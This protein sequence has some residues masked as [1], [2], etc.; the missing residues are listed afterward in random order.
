MKRTPTSRRLL[1]VRALLLGC[2]FA[3]PLRAITKSEV[4]IPNNLVSLVASTHPRLLVTSNG[5]FTA[6]NTK[7]NS[8]D[9][10]MVLWKNKL[11]ARS[12]EIQNL[13]LEPLCV[14][15]TTGLSSVGGVVLERVYILALHYKLGLTGAAAAKTRL[16]SELTNIMGFPNWV[17]GEMVGVAKMTEAVA[18]AYDWLYNDWTANQ[19]TQLRAAIR[20][21]G[22]DPA[23]D[24]YSGGANWTQ[25]THNYNLVINSGVGMGALAICGQEPVIGESA[26]QNSLDHLIDGIAEYSSGGAWSEG[27][28]YWGFATGT[29]T[30]YLA[31]LKTAIGEDFGLSDVAGFCDTGNASLYTTNPLGKRYNFGDSDDDLGAM[32]FLFW[33]A[34]R[35]AKPEYGAWALTAADLPTIGTGIPLSMVFYDPAW[36]PAPGTVSLASPDKYFR[37]LETVSLRKSWTSV[38]DTM[39]VLKGYKDGVENHNDLDSGSFYL[40]ALGQV[41]AEDLGNDSYSLPGYQNDGSASP[42]RWDYYRKRPQGHNTLVIKPSGGVDQVPYAATP[43][44]RYKSSAGESFAIMDMT[45]AYPSGKNVTSAKRGVR[46]FGPQKKDV[47]VQDEVSMSTAGDADWYMHVKEPQSSFVIDTTDN[48]SATITTS[49]GN[50][51][52]L[53]ILNS[54]GQF[55]L[56]TAQPPANPPNQNP[57]N[58]YNKLNIHLTNFTG[59]TLCVYMVPLRPG[60]SPP[61]SFPPIVAMDSWDP[62]IP[63]TTDLQPVADA[64]VKAGAHASTNFGVQD[65]FAVK[66]TPNTGDTTRESFLRFDLSSISRTIVDAKLR[67]YCTSVS[68]TPAPVDVHG[69]AVDTWTEGGITWNN[70]PPKTLHL[71][72]NTVG[73]VGWKELNVTAYVLSQFDRDGIVS[74]ALMDDSKANVQSTFSSKETLTTN[75]PLLRITTQ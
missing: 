67:V 69:V 18:I 16:W 5:A 36:C 40:Y 30:R 7:I 32:P 31:S 4:I 57:N 23:L 2:V 26:L 41:W 39:V 28:T 11:I 38:D 43:I 6:I 10:Y 13:Q 20:D 62:E 75:K 58:G 24:D 3:L 55:S 52:W 68:A 42:N 8:G 33:H 61:T 1:V 44:R 25:V 59:I 34:K 14:Y 48:K 74:L 15:D 54:K 47:I 27:P 73:A 12:T 9:P 49:D 35:F 56:M 19:R 22:L 17:P 37:G 53:R 64:L 71:S 46:L 45:A 65:S 72:I 66:G 50:R 51:L 29:V 60:E 63:A 21:K 70:A